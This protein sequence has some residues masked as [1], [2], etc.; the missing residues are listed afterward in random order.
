MNIFARAYNRLIRDLV[1]RYLERKGIHHDF[2]LQIATS[3]LIKDWKNCNQ[4]LK[5]KIWAVRRGFYPSRIELYGLNESNYKMYLSDL[6]YRKIFPL[7]NSF[8]KWLDDKLT[9][10]YVFQDARIID[11]MPQYYIY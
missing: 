3:G 9:T 7:N 4:P 5:Q 10:K 11:F 1:C 6:D 8:Q 2:I